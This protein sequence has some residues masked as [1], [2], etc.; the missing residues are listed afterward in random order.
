MF[1]KV[2]ESSRAVECEAAGG[3]ALHVWDTVLLPGLG[4]WDPGSVISAYTPTGRK[5]RLGRGRTPSR[6]EGDPSG[7]PGWTQPLCRIAFFPTAALVMAASWG[8]WSQPS[9]TLCSGPS[10][11][12]TAVLQRASPQGSSRQ[13]A[14]VE[15]GLQQ[16]LQ[17]SGTFCAGVAGGAAGFAGTGQLMWAF[18]AWLWAGDPHTPS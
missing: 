6:R 1:G 17:S 5:G 9:L 10:G 11:S 14:P 3:S 8:P 4:G 13:P 7:G 12:V 18:W 15:P 16:T 2:L